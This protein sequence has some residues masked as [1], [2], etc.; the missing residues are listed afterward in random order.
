MISSVAEEREDE[1]GRDPTSIQDCD[2]ASGCCL[3]GAS[4]ER[5]GAMSWRWGRVLWLG[6]GYA[7]E[8]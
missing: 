8:P 6:V 2:M 3:A 5:R 4:L 7:R 1:E